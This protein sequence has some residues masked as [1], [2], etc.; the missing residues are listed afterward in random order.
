MDLLAGFPVVTEYPVV[1]GE[2]D[3]NQHV[4]HIV[5]FRYFE[6]GRA[7]YFQR[8]GLYDFRRQTNM[9]A[10]LSHAEARFRKPLTFPDTVSVGTRLLSIGDDRFTL[11]SS[12]VSH[13][14][15]VVAAEGRGTM[16]T[17][18]YG[19][20]KKIPMPEELRRRIAE[21]EASVKK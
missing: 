11:E 20:A 14:H 13:R 5:Y 4:N 15:G 12:L 21:L 9:G 19:E 2:M 6:S 10:I 7:E 8:M 3:A 17:Y 1:W 16:V 18:D